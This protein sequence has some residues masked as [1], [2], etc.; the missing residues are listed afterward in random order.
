VPTTSTPDSF[1][2]GLD[3]VGLRETQQDPVVRVSDF[4][5]EKSWTHHE[6]V[7]S[8]VPARRDQSKIRRGGTHA[9]RVWARWQRVTQKKM[10]YL[11]GNSVPARI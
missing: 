1:D 9:E 5:E 10:R 3:P 2:V 8:S 7:R 4:E 11:D 6:C